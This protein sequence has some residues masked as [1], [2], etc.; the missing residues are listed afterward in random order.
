MGSKMTIGKRFII[1][2]GVLLLLSTVSAIVT[3]LG[4]SGIGSNVHS[5]ATDSVPGLYDSAAMRGDVL[6]LRGD[7]L[8]HIGETDEATMNQVEQQIVANQ[9][10][11]ASDMKSYDETIN[12]EDDRAN[13]A[14]LA[15]ELAALYQG[16]DAVHSLSLASKNVEA[17]ALYKSAMLPHMDALHDQLDTIVEWNS[18]A[19][20]TTIAE[21]TQT[22]QTTW[23]VALLMGIVSLIVGVGV[24]WFMIAALNKELAQT[25]TELSEGAVQIAS[26]ASQVASSSQSLAQG[27][28]EQAASLEETSSTTEEINS[29]AGR[30]SDNSNVMTRMVAESQL[31]FVT[32]N[33]QLD[34]MVSAMDEINSSSAKI[35]KIIKVID[36]IAFQTNI[37]ALN[38]AVEAARAGEAGMGFAVVADEVRNL[39]QRCAQAAKDTAD[40]IEDSIGKSGGG[41]AKVGLVAT[42]IQRITGEFE[43]IKTLVDEVSCGSKEQT[44]GIGLIRQSLS[45]MELVSQ[46]TA[47][48]AEQGAAAAEQLNAQSEALKDI[49]VRLNSMAGVTHMVRA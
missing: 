24:S 20:H 19:A 5:L 12:E 1:T 45:Q 16:W 27:S 37:L 36:E 22:V 4:L 33:L 15:P 26:A 40:L 39:A 14:K 28:S 8:R 21:T 13:F 42:A 11:L 30:N 48:G 29:M 25:I 3:I 7:Y 2:S 23:L 44:D 6:A 32:T 38:A 18:K 34:E 47:A 49:V 17:F 10:K 46:S 9:Q 43:K 31:E 35:G 41:K